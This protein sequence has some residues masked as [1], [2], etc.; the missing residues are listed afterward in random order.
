MVG[1]FVGG[2]AEGI[3]QY[4]MD[5]RR[6]MRPPC[7]VPDRGTVLRVTG[8]G[9]A[10]ATAGASRSVR[11]PDDVAIR[12]GVAAPEDVVVPGDGATG[13]GS[14]RDGHAGPAGG[15]RAGGSGR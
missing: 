6:A 15:R 11:L 5:V 13:A 7:A 2:P 4:R 8:D 14:G 1:P 3:D 10:T 9:G 12:D